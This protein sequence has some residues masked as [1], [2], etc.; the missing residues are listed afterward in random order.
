MGL[1]GGFFTVQNKVLNGAYI[2]FISKSKASATLS[3]RGVATM[4]L[5][6]DWGVD[7]AIFEV[8][9][10]DFQKNSMKI[11]GYPYTHKKMKGLRDLF[12]NIK[13]LYAYKLT[14][15][16]VKAS[17]AFAAAKHSGIRGN[18]LKVVISANVDTPEA[19][20][21]RLYLDTTVVFEQEA[22]N[23]AADL[24]DS[25]YVDWKKDVML[26]LTAGTP[27]S[28]GTNGAV[29]G[30][31]HQSY[32][33][34][35]ESYSFNTM[36]VVVED[37]I[38]KS[39]YAAYTKRMR[40]QVGAK[41]QCVLHRY[42]ADHEG[43][44][45]VKNN[46]VQSASPA[47]LVYWVTG[48]QAGCAVNK[49]LLNRVYDGEYQVD[50]EYTQSQLERAMQS[51]EFM[52]HNVNGVVR[53][54]ADINS[55]VSGTEEKLTEHF[56]SNQ[57]IRVLDQIANDIAVIFC[58]KYLGLVPNDNPGRISLW[59]DIVKHHNELQKIRAIQEFS[60]DDV[61]VYQGDSKDSVVVDDAVNAVVGMAKLYQTIIV[62]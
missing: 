54:L 48:A 29:D 3:D 39:L 20:D 18:D 49:T 16:G 37:E 44:I 2:N 30:A 62:S 5:E 23:T 6:L 57:I 35:A 1:G 31:A 4:P 15:G 17:N 14:S 40:E 27:L 51:G 28:G 22:V 13:T 58:T 33:D 41:F 56:G 42:A 47:D 61:S 60:A 59:S 32:L 43:V 50:V 55:F 26:A 21:V 34:K 53:V 46:A 36:G 10:A 45:N 38:T 11:F 24:L 19:F 25:D 7:A 8:T 12:R 52:F 9:P